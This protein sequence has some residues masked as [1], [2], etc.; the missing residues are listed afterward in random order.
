M[1]PGR[2]VAK[3]KTGLKTPTPPRGVPEDESA[4]TS[5][6]SSN[7]V[8]ATLQSSFIIDQ[9]S[10]HQNSSPTSIHEA[11]DYLSK[12]AKKIMHEHALMKDEL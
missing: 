9:I 3:L 11:V 1:D 5:K 10:Q 4:Y 8:E 2:V 12:G 7:P 6:T